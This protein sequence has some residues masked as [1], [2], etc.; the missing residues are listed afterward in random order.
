MQVDNRV[1]EFCTYQ[2]TDKSND[3]ADN[4]ISNAVLFDS[5]ISNHTSMFIALITIFYLI[6]YYFA[7]KAPIKTA[8]RAIALGTAYWT[9]H[10]GATTTEN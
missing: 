8:L 6:T 3:I 10:L 9:Y 2:I 1:G 7:K 5:H 4:K